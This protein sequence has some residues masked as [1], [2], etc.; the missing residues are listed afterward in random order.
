MHENEMNL[1]YL[2]H[3]KYK[4]HDLISCLIKRNAHG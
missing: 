1:E 3:I 4:I 2:N